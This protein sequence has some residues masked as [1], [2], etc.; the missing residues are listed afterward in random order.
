MCVAGNQL[1]HVFQAVWTPVSSVSASRAVENELKMEAEKPKRSD[2]SLH[3]VPAAIAIHFLLG[4][5]DSGKIT[6]TIVFEKIITIVIIS[7]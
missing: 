1:Y 6:I 2:I 4:L 7:R 3:K 5:G